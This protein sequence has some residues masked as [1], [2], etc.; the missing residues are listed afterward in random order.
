M[1]GGG[2]GGAL[3]FDAVH[4]GAA[5]HA[6]LIRD[7]QRAEGLQVVDP[8]LAQH[9]GTARAGPPLR[10]QGGVQP[11]RVFWVRR[12]VDEAGEVAGVSTGETGQVQFQAP[13][14]ADGPV[15]RE[16]AIQNVVPPATLNPEQQVALGRGR[17][18]AAGVPDRG[19]VA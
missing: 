17:E 3:E 19:K 10:H 15:G 11:I 5:D 18:R 16:G 7:R 9:E 13:G 1:G 6:L 14:R 8:F 12:A 4:L 2:H